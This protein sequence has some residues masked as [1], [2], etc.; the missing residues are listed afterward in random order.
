MARVSP[1]CGCILAATTDK[2]HGQQTRCIFAPK[3]APYY[4]K[5][6]G[7]VLYNEGNRLLVTVSN[8]VSCL[9]FATAIAWIDHLITGP[10]REGGWREG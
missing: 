7:T 2:S 9:T 3:T 10:L 8:L 4:R 5:I 1:V 6:S